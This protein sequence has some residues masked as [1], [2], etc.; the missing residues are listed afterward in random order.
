MNHK[1]EHLGKIF[2]INEVE[3]QYALFSDKTTASKWRPMGTRYK[4]LVKAGEVEVGEE[5]PKEV[6]ALAREY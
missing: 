4:L 5:I 2:T 1:V 6:A 3:C